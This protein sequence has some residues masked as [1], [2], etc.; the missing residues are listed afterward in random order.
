MKRFDER[1]TM[2]ARMNYIEG[3]EIYNDYYSKNTDLKEGDDSL[4]SLPTMGGEGSVMFNSINSPIV[5]ASFKYLYDIRKF[6]EGEIAPSKAEVDPVI[7]TEK[8]KGLAKFYNAK[9][10][11]ITEMKDYH[12]YSHRGRHEE[13]Y[14]EEIN[15][16]HKYGIVFAVAMDKEMIMRAPKLPESIAVT[17]GYVES[18]TIGMILSYYIRELGYDARNHMDG[19]YLVIAPLVARDAGLGEFGRNGLLI[20]KEDGACV[21]LGV[22][23]TDMPIVPDASE[24][25]GVKEFCL[26]CGRC[27]KTCPGKA[28]SKTEMAED[29]GILRWKINAEECYRRWRSLGTDC[30]ICIANCPF[31]YGISKDLISNIKSSPETRKNIL[32]DFDEKYGIRPII[33]EEPEWLK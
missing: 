7:M 31:T 30:G 1:D 15:R 14:G 26:D 4:R 23:T 18:A 29:E 11:G 16:K 5:D 25:F 24:D 21:R 28:I 6:S 9:L 32:K 2:F 17:K 19:N 13:N 8:I 10:V 33:R 12:Y 22:V 27:S 20:T 3:S